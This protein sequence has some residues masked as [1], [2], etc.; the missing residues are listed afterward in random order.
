MRRYHQS[1]TEAF[2]HAG[3]LGGYSVVELHPWYFRLDRARNI[4]DAFRRCAGE[5]W[6]ARYAGK[7]SDLAM[8]Y[9]IG[10][11]LEVSAASREP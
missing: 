1:A 9:S 10:C 5:D 11:S 3:P 6:D 4:A 8:G 7:G 2:C